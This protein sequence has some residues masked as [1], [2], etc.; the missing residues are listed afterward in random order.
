MIIYIIVYQSD[1]IQI[2]VKIT[3]YALLELVVVFIF[4]EKN[5]QNNDVSICWSVRQNF[6]ENAA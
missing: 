4:V 5:T 1:R 3:E 2:N 6:S